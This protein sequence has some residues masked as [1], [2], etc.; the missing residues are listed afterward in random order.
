MKLIVHVV[1]VQLVSSALCVIG[2]SLSDPHTNCTAVQNPPD[3]YIYNKNIF[4][5]NEMRC[6]D[7]LIVM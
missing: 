4:G 6:R 3:I 1:R 7:G 5:K 2:A